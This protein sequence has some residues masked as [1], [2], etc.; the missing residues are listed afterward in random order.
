MQAFWETEN[1]QPV[2]TA[3]V[4]DIYSRLTEEV[5]QFVLGIQVSNLCPFFDNTHISQ[6]KHCD[7][8]TTH[9]ARKPITPHGH[10]SDVL[11]PCFSHPTGMIRYFH[12]IHQL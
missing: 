8:Y 4:V 11:E 12:S 5:V 1:E 10:R 9:N 2:Y 6:C 7:K 3:L